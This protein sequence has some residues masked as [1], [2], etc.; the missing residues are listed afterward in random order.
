M[1]VMIIFAIIGFIILLIFFGAVKASS[2][3]ARKEEQELEREQAE[4]YT[5]MTF[6]GDYEAFRNMTKRRTGDDEH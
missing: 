6:S 2:R 3:A 5:R 4:G 1:A